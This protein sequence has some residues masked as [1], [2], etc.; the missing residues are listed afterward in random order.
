MFRILLYDVEPRTQYS[1]PAR[2]D[3][4]LFDRFDL[5]NVFVILTGKEREE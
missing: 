4:E 2:K 5:V 1:L 3:E